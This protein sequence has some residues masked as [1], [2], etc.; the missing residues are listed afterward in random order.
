ML[1]VIIPTYNNKS[2]TIRN[3]H[4][5]DVY[6]RKHF[7]KHEIIL[8]DDGSRLQE[9]A[10][11]EEL[12]ADVTHIR[13]PKNRGKGFAIQQGM[14]KARGDC[15]IFTDIDLPYALEAFPYAYDLIVNKNINVVVGDRKLAISKCNIKISVFR[16]I[17]SYVFSKL[18]TL[19]IIGGVF[20][21]QCGF[22]AFSKRLASLLFPLL[23]VKRFGFDVEIYYLLLK[24]N[25]MM[26]KIPVCLN[27]NSDSTVQPIMHGIE[28][29]FS[30]IKIVVNYKRGKYG[31][32]EL[33]SLE[34][35][36]YWESF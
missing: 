32:L 31:A 29:L 7:K 14:A 34:N 11:E 4:L 13:L 21:F 17:A 16:R 24:N 6:L 33:S 25:I 5:L 23:K 28:T 12:P 2:L 30:V 8:V 18:V 9:I 35:V 1:S 15:C 19:F 22:K 20:D 10:A 26:K 27:N 3:I 36:P